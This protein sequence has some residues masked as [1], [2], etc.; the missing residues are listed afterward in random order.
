MYYYI[1]SALFLTMLFALS[2]SSI[3]SIACLASP[4]PA[5]MSVSVLELALMDFCRVAPVGLARAVLPEVKALL[6]FALG[7]LLSNLLNAVFRCLI[8]RLRCFVCA[9]TATRGSSITLSGLNN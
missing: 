2:A 4:E 8:C 9:H 6:L 5:I 1:A 7:D 3:A